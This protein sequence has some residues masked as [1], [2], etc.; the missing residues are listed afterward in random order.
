MK[1]KII[2]LVI[3]I[4]MCSVFLSFLPGN[5]STNTNVT[6]FQQLREMFE[7]PPADFKPATLWAWNDEMTN[8]KIDWFLMDLYKT[9]YREIYIFPS[10]GLITPYLSDEWFSACRHLVDRAKQLNLKI[11]IYD[12]NSYP[13]GFAGGHVPAEMPESANQGQGLVMRRSDSFPDN[14]DGKY[15]IILKKEGDGFVDVTV[16]KNSETDQKGEYFTFEKAY[17]SK[18]KWYGGYSYVDLLMDG[19]TEK[20][21]DVTFSGY[22]KAIGDEFGKTVMGIFTDEPHIS[23]PGGRNS[24]RWTPVLFSE[25]QKRWGYDLKT[26]L[27]SL[28]EEVGDWKRIRHNYYS[29][30]T[31]LFIERWGKVYYNY[32]KNK[33]LIFTGHYWEHSWPNPEN[34]GD[35]M[36]MYA[37]QHMPGID[38]LF[39]DYSELLYGQLGN[40]RSVKEL[41]SVANQLGRPRTLSETYGGTGWPL[42]FEDIKRIGDWEF[43]FGVNY[44]AQFSMQTIMGGRKHDYPPAFSYQ[45]HWWRFYPVILNYQTRMSFA[46]SSGKQQNKILVIEPTTSTWMYFSPSKSNSAFQSSG[47][48]FHVLIAELDRFQIEYD[49]GSEAII[50]DYG[51]AKDGKF[52]IGDCSYDL[53]V[54]PPGLD[55]LNKPTVS[56]LENYINQGGK[57]VS[58]G[59]YPECI[60]GAPSGRMKAITA[61]YPDRYININSIES[62]FSTGIFSTPDFI[63][64]NPGAIAGKFFHQRRQLEDGTLLFLVNT[65]TEETTA[66]S[67]TAKGKSVWELDMLSGIIKPYPIKHDGNTVSI[68]FNVT[69][70]GSQLL[71]ISNN[72]TSVPVEAPKKVEK[73]ILTPEGNL[74][75]ERVE[76]NVVV[77]DYCDYK[78]SEI[79]EKDVYFFKAGADIFKHYGFDGNPWNRAVQFN[80]EILDKNHFPENSGFEA[81]FSFQVEGPV[82]VSSMQAVIERPNLWKVSI[83]GNPVV[84]RPEEWWLDKAFGIYDIGKFVTQGKNVLTT[85]SSPF[86]VHSELEPVFIRGNFNLEPGVQGWKIIPVKPVTL[87]KWTDQGMPFYPGGIKYTKTY[88]I[89]KN[90]RQFYIQLNKWLGSVAE[91]LVNGKSAGII[92]WPPYT[93]DITNMV[94]EGDNEILV[95]VYGTLIN[96]LGP[97]HAEMLHGEVRPTLFTKAPDQQPPGSDYVVTG[98]GLF[99]D[100][101]VFEE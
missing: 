97:Y 60:D 57:I 44:L 30:L 17:H 5:G 71:F 94:R 65:D 59:T 42:R 89:S 95:V 28:I 3:K 12:E 6:S 38:V 14:K 8:E 58:L 77:I 100:F 52:I 51:L 53:V 21:L 32:C 48:S 46:L 27:V 101:V 86:T 72:A 55:N 56:L 54:F 79:E 13:S 43:A 24:I 31:E 74:K 96:L 81:G 63:V 99:D 1:R 18:S 62:G 80:S 22:E 10:P 61:K 64:T 66:G 47:E 73:T 34:N 88:K 15:F 37:W 67:I 91:V 29:L 25:F 16:Q 36:A 2:F 50:K 78:L 23:P 93:C 82:D 84:S 49:L 33:N 19:V 98:Y 69:P 39:N 83:N 4:L 40:A 70:V 9:G 11:W 26:N 90:D 45:A 76:P 20:F 92:G 35:N 7:N 85:K 87:G 68:N 75:V 41:S